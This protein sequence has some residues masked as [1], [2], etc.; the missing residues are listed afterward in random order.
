MTLALSA[1]FSASRVVTLV[2]SSLI[3]LIMY[4]VR[5]FELTLLTPVDLVSTMSGRI[6]SS[7][8]AIT[9]NCVPSLSTNAD[10]GLSKSVISS[11]VLYS[12]L[13]T[14]IC[15]ILSSPILLLTIFFLI[16]S[17]EVVDHALLFAVLY[18][19]LPDLTTNV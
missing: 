14:C 17:S 9:P 6:V 10:L 5:L 16:L 1:V 12:K 7:S 8:C 2:E 11:T 15:F 18:A 13:R 19:P 4:Q 3:A